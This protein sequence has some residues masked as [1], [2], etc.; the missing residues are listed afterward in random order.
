MV[1]EREAWALAGYSEDVTETALSAKRPSTRVVYDTRW[2]AFSDWCLEKQVEPTSCSLPVVLDFL[3]SLVRR[4]RAVNTVRGYVSALSSRHAL[5]QVGRDLVP[6]GSA[7]PVRTW[8]RGLS[9]QHPPP[10]VRVP[11]WELEVVLSALSS[12]PFFPLHSCD[13]KH[14]TLRTVFLVAIISAKRASELHALRHDTSFRRPSEFVL[15]ADEAF[16]PKV[17][18]AW[19]RNKPVVV[20]AIPD[21]A[22]GVLRKLCAY[23]SLVEYIDRTKGLY[24]DAR[25]PQLFLCYG[26]AKA[27]RPVSKQRVSTWLKEVV[28]YSYSLQGLPSPSVQ[29][30]DT[31]R[32][33]TSWAHVAG[34]DPGVICEAATWS[35]SSTFARFYR[36]DV[37]R[38]DLADFG[39]RVL[40]SA[41]ATS[42]S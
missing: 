42:V 21:D 14:L 18:T 41:C 24:G 29:G 30:H 3:Q 13:L 4:G 5:V 36:L 32:Q 15:F 28:H 1:V 34:V 31:R 12:P 38:S 27:G 10:T 2:Q 11:A 20:G 19:H 35:S 8:L 40:S 26:D 33:A 6:L 22:E 25:P 39:R 37:L 7:P 17:A 16:L 23:R 9:K